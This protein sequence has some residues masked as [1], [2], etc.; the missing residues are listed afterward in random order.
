MEPMWRENDSKIK[1]IY[2]SIKKNI[3]SRSF[4]GFEHLIFVPTVLL[5]KIAKARGMKNDLRNTVLI[6]SEQCFC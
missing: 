1:K 2:E 5:T 4:R 3:W 6:K